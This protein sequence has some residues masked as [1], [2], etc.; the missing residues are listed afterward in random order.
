MPDWGLVICQCTY[1]VALN[2][3][4]CDHHYSVHAV[5]FRTWS[6]MCLAKKVLALTEC[7]FMLCNLC[8]TNPPTIQLSGGM[9]LERRVKVNY[10]FVQSE[11]CTN[12]RVGHSR[13]IQL[14]SHHRA[15]VRACCMIFSCDSC[16]AWVKRLRLTA[17]QCNMC[18]ASL[19]KT[20]RTKLW[21]QMPV[22]SAPN[23]CD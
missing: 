16:I 10:Q 23:I 20:C 17:G 14:W 9:S 2:G 21:H 15:S 11:C 7:S 19:K 3:W 4:E 13:C 18:M 6:T 8:V 22:I 1:W 12:Q 5:Y